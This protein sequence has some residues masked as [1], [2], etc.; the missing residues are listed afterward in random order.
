MGPI[1]ALCIAASVFLGGSV[2]SALALVLI[3][4]TLYIAVYGRVVRG[5]WTS[6]KTALAQVDEV[7]EVSTVG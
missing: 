1:I 2:S 7:D 5:R 4:L 6:S 3:Q